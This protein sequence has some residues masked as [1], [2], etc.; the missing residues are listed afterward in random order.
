MK[1]RPM[2]STQLHR[3]KY[4]CSDNSD[5]V[6]PYED[7]IDGEVSTCPIQNSFELQNGDRFWYVNRNLYQNKYC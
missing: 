1:T 2:C 5:V 3:L 6:M 7:G 4:S